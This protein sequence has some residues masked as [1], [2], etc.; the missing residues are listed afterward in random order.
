MAVVAVG[1]P[2]GPVYVGASP[3]KDGTLEPSLA[4]VGAR[5]VG[6][7]TSHVGGDL[8]SDAALGHQF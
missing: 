3:G 8:E 6:V 5:G 7:G 2:P 1:V 4:G